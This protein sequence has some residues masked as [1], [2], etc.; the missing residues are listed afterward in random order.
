MQ[1]SIASDLQA[2][3]T[4]EKKAVYEELKFKRLVKYN[5][6]LTSQKDKIA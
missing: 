5:P 1:L 3:S 4:I 2:K 6:S